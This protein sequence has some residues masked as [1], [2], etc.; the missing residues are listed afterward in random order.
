SAARRGVVL[1]PAQCSVQ[2]TG[3]DTVSVLNLVALGCVERKDTLTD[4]TGRPMTLTPSTFAVNGRYQLLRAG[5]IVAP[6]G[7]DPFLSRHPR[8]V[9]GTAA[10]GR[11]MLVTID[12]RSAVS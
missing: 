12:G 4:T 6:T 9:A 11:I 2:A 3:L 7:N 10:D 1:T 5:R 8:T